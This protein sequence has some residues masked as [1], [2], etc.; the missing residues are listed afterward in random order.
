MKIPHRRWLAVAAVIIASIGVFV[1]PY[2]MHSS[3]AQSNSSPNSHGTTTTA[4]NPN[5]QSST[6]HG[7]GSTT[8]SGT[9]DT[10][11]TETGSCD[12]DSSDKG[13]D[14]TG[15]CSDSDSD[16]GST[17]D[18]SS[19]QSNCGHVGEDE[20]A[21]NDHSMASHH[22]DD[23]LSGSLETTSVAHMNH[24]HGHD[25]DSDELSETADS[26]ADNGQED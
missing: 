26:C 8:T 22:D 10:G 4:T 23:S 20:K 16:D 15:A 25:I 18:Q 9:T 13:N 19:T 21:D 11:G 24:G 17:G 2:L 12:D 6:T 7:T 1:A 14:A 3:P 5:G